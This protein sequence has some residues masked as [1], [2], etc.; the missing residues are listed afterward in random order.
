MKYKK[1]KSY[2][3]LNLALNITGK[4]SY[5]H[6]IES[7]IAFIELHDL[8]MIKCIKSKKHNISFRG[9]FS[10]NITKI[11]TVS[12]LLEVLEKKKFLK[13]RKFKIIIDKRIPNRS[14]LG[15][16]S[17]NAANIL[18]YLKKKKFIKIN[19]KKLIEVS[20]LIGSDV[21]LGLNPTYSVLSPKNKL[22]YFY[23]CK[24]I[25]T[26][27]IKPNF[28]CS[29]KEIYSKVKK[30]DRQKFKRPNKQ[31]FNLENLKKMSNSLEPL[32]FLKYPI[33]KAVK[34]FLVENFPKMVFAR[35]TGS[36]SAI[37]AYFRSKN[38]C[39]NAK[40]N[41]RKKYRNFWCIS[42]KTI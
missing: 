22:S 36:G 4:N 28:G 37:V 1:I 20:N 9:K 13:D 15:G 7:I 42:S 26:L 5:L 27:V 32:V 40:K 19:K 17:M 39:E 8:I 25:Y 34:S 24:S 23:G 6:K 38:N 18:N 21:I 31:L 33:L 12:R 14:G 11:N 29:S 10:K 30:F 16:G 35:M 2:A 41:F 3:K